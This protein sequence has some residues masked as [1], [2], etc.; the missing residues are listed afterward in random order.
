MRL[1]QKVLAMSAGAGTSGVHSVYELEAVTVEHWCQALLFEQ[2]LAAGAV[3]GPG[4]RSD[5]RKRV[6]SAESVIRRCY[7]SGS[8]DALPDIDALMVIAK[9]KQLLGLYPDVL[10]VLN[11]VLLAAD[12]SSAPL[13]DV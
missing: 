4:P 10:N 12:P 1:A 11:Q 9:G 13:P 5:L 7:S 2:Q 6:I 8:G 3:T